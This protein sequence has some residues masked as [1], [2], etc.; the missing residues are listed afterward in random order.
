MRKGSRSSIM[1]ERAEKLQKFMREKKFPGCFQCDMRSGRSSTP[2]PVVI[3]FEQVL[4]VGVGSYRRLSIKISA[5]NEGQ[6]FL[7]HD[8][9][10]FLEE[11]LA[12]RKNRR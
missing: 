5:S 3:P 11:Y 4:Y 10:R 2:T 9:M 8:A 1:D 6:F 12:W 7:T